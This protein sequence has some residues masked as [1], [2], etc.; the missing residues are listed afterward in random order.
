[1]IPKPGGKPVRHWKP[2][3]K[4]VRAGGKT[5]NETFARKLLG[6]SAAERF[7]P[8]AGSGAYDRI[9]A[10]LVAERIDGALLDKPYAMQK[11]AELKQA[12]GAELALTDVTPEIFPGV[13]LEKM[14]FAVR[15]T[16]RAL[17]QELNSNS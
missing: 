7:V 2:A 11:T 14:G 6:D 16:D 1:M 4:R 5:T 15:K 9:M 17:L 8:Y 13:E 10:D 3:L 12:I